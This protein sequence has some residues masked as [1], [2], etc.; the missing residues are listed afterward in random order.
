M[1]SLPSDGRERRLLVTALRSYS[2]C[3]V[4]GDL[5]RDCPFA[6]RTR[7][8]LGC[9]EEC[10]DLLANLDDPNEPV[11]VALGLGI[12]IAPMLRPRARRG[13]S[14]DTMPFD[15][16]QH[17]LEELSL[18]VVR[19]SPASL[20]IGMMDELGEPPPADPSQR[21]KRALTIQEIVSDLYRRGFDVEVL[22][23]EAF[24]PVIA[25]MTASWVIVRI[26][27]GEDAAQDWSYAE[28][29]GWATL[30]LDTD[31]LSKTT[32]AIRAKGHDGIQKAIESTLGTGRSKI[33]NWMATLPID[34][35]IAWVVPTRAQFE[36]I[37]DAPPSQKGGPQAWMMERFTNTYLDAWSTESLHFEWDYIHGKVVPPCNAAQMRSRRIS[38]EELALAIAHRATGTVAGQSR[39]IVP[40]GK[41]VGVATDLLRKGERASAAALFDVAC[42]LSPRSGDALNNRGFCRLPDDPEGALRDFE[43]AM[44]SGV[45]DLAVATA[46]RMLALHRLGRN[47]S[48]ISLA[49]DLWTS[50]PLPKWGAVVWDFRTATPTLIDTEDA[51]AYTA[52]LAAFIGSAVGDESLAE[53]WRTRLAERR[54]ERRD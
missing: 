44:D 25:S 18:P 6:I 42:E 2:Y 50:S 41:Y 13:P 51:V 49:E 43:R 9:G 15:S 35:L 22:L 26:V 4:P 45:F 17:F 29:S 14:P 27:T 36:A 47:T 11:G 34:D 7:D 32:S 23:R 10:L 16:R 40:H 39:S 8:G 24:V 30:V 33:E 1:K 38:R 46:N 37:S 19:R 53:V 31:D 3:C 20:F 28:R 12:R 54:A 52:E 48:A 21:A 5:H